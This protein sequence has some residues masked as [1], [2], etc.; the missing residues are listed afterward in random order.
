MSLYE[1]IVEELIKQNKTISIMES[2]AGGAVVNEI[3]TITKG[4]DIIKFGAVTYSDEF[5]IK[6]GVSK[7]LL[8]K[9]TSN[10]EEIA[11]EMSK[12]I[13]DFASSDLGIGITGKIDMNNTY[14]QTNYIYVSVYDK[15]KD[16]Y[17]V[18]KVDAIHPLRK[19][20]KKLVTQVLVYML[21]S[22]I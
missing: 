1:N 7:E 9:Y 3:T 14:G 2:C 21:K 12:K 16:K 22:M 10:S 11:K 5:K 13:C 4:C 19:D 8:E 17:L 18:N 20:N 15:S 6:M